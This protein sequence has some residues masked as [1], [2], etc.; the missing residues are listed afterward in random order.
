MSKKRRQKVEKISKDDTLT[1][2]EKSML[3]SQMDGD[4]LKKQKK[5]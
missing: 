2:A 4:N 3:V 1:E 5:G